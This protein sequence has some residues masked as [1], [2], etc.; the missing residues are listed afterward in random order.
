MRCVPSQPMSDERTEF[1]KRLIAAMTAA[2]YEARPGILLKRFNSTYRGR[3]VSFQTASRWLKG[4]GIPE[5][6]KLQVLAELY[7][8]APQELRY[9]E[10]SSRR[11]A[12]SRPAWLH[13]LSTSDQQMLDAYLLLPPAQR[14]LVRELIAALAG[15]ETLTRR[16]A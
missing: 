16:R 1:S 6:D 8:V 12:D 13:E 15:T 7:G 4:Q 11:I 2:G 10:R 14:R 3:S 5:Q 9:G